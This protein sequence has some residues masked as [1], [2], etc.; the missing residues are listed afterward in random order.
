MRHAS[1]GEVYD[2]GLVRWHI[3]RLRKEL[4]DSP[5]KRIV[6]FRGFGYRFDVDGPSLASL[7]WP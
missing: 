4:G 2:L 1:Q 6:H 5:H 7:P 3:A